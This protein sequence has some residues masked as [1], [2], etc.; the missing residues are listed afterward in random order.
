MEL[1]AIKSTPCDII[2]KKSLKYIRV[3]FFLY[4]LFSFGILLPH[5]RYATC[6]IIWTFEVS[7]S[8]SLA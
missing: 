7:V 6:K 1:D 4:I 3:I 8:H 2:Q 5:N